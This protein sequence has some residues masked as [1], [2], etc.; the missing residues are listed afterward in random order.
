METKY[1][2]LHY[3]NL[4]GRLDSM[5]RVIENSKANTDRIIE[6]LNDNYGRF[7]QA[8]ITHHSYLKEVAEQHG[9]L[10]ALMHHQVMLETYQSMLDGYRINR[11]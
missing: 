8:S 7:L 11:P 3:G 1:P 10:A 4:Q 2:T 5:N 6:S 9:D